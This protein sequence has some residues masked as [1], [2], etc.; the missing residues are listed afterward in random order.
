VVSIGL[1]LPFDEKN[2]PYFV[3]DHGVNGY[4]SGLVPSATVAGRVGHFDSFRVFCTLS[5]D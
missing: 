4:R 5:I 3:Y 2:L 1:V